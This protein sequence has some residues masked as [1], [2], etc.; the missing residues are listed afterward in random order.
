MITIPIRNSNFKLTLV[1]AG[2]YYTDAGT[3]M[4]VLPKALW[5]KGLTLSE[6]DSIPMALNCLLIQNNKTNILVDTGV[7]NIL[8][9]KQ[10]KIYRPSS[11]ELLNNL[12]SLG[13]DRND[14]DHVVL[15]HLHF[16][17]IGGILSKEFQDELTFPKACHHIQKLEWLTASNPDELN[18]A[19]Y[20]FQH[21]LSVLSDS[22]NLN[23]IDGDTELFPN[24]EL[25]LVQGHSEGM[26]IIKIKADDRV[27]YYAGDIFPSELHL[28]PA[29]T[30]AYDLCRKTT[31][32]AKKRI[33]KELT[34]TH[35]MLI[36]NHDPNKSFI[37]F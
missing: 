24:I 13:I 4:G 36:F 3:A 8:T 6:N 32:T 34:D 30:S 11:F 22:I 31:Y 26:Q 18:Q 23:I 27:I 19:A 20:P 9:E 12:K 33:I 2:Q 29:I 37:E 35:G 7:G 17:H 15:T 21:H 5:K 10:I 1:S 25:Q 16:D 28:S 14:I